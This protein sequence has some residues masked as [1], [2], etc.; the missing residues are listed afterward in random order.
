MRATGKDIV[1][2]FGYAP[3]DLSASATDAFNRSHCP[4]VNA[5]CSKTN[6]DQTVVYGTCA[7]TSGKE[8]IIICPKRMYAQSY[9]VFED[10]IQEIWGQIPLV[11]GGNTA[12]LKLK[13]KQHL[14]C[15]VAFGQ[16]SGKEISINSH[17]KLSIDW[18][19]QRY[20]CLNGKLQPIDFVA[21]EVQSID[22]TGNYREAHLA[23]S[24]LKKRTLV[25]HIPDAAH[26][27]N[28]A[29]VHKRLIPQ[30][31]RKG[32][33]YIKM[34]RCVG[35]IFILPKQVYEKFD[36]ILGFIP[37]ET[38]NSRQNLSVFT[39][40]LDHKVAHDNKRALRFEGIKRHS[41]YNIVTAFTTNTQDNAPT[42]L[43]KV[44]KTLL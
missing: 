20:K 42:E 12:D 28:W 17:G 23:Y 15:V 32:N 22:I 2:L 35:F 10:V 41:L 44:L 14:E 8:E 24:S 16:R 7:V 5:R 33:I 31:I 6:H 40:S 30:I 38:S 18:V 43:D 13:A 25:N 3:D 21:I 19:L 36:N 26:G 11:I 4:F 1:E 9:R 34:A 37:E 29:N 39:Y 27:M